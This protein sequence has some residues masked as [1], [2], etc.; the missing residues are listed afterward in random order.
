MQTYI[1][2][3]APK[4]FEHDVLLLS[5]E[6]TFQGFPGHL[7]K[8]LEDQG[9]STMLVK[10]QRE[11]EREAIEYSRII[12]IILSDSYATCSSRLDTLAEIQNDFATGR[13]IFPIFHYVDPSVVRKRSGSYKI[14]LDSKKEYVEPDKLKNWNDALA[15]LAD[16]L[17][18][19]LERVEY[20]YQCIPKI[21]RE[22][23]KQVPCSV[24]LHRRVHEVN[25]LL[26]SGSDDGVQTVGIW[27]EPGIGKTMIARGV[28]N[29]NVGNGFDFCCFL[30]K[31]GEY[32][33]S[34][35]LEDLIRMLVS[36]IGDNDNN[37]KF[38][39]DA[40]VMS[41][42]DQK[43]KQ[44]KVFLVLE[45]ICDQQQL[46]V[47][48]ELTNQF[49][50]NSKVIATA[51]KDC[52][53]QHHEIKTYEVERFNKEEALELLSLKS[54]KCNKL[55]PKYMPILEEAETHASG[56]PLILEVIGSYLCGKSPE[57]CKSVLDQYGK[58]QNG[59]KQMIVQISFDSLEKD[60]KRIV[61]CPNEQKK[62]YSELCNDYS[63]KDINRL[64][65]ISLIKFNKDGMM[66]IHDFTKNV[67]RLDCFK[68]RQLQLF[69]GNVEDYGKLEIQPTSSDGSRIYD[70]MKWECR[71]PYFQDHL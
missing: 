62:T 47:I 67:L 9:L 50:S 43:L 66:T 20:E 22:I 41:K 58:I 53:L 39:N 11:L 36:K 29:S 33:S 48:V 25:A 56:V 57:Q 51:E 24:G 5:D 49:G 38:E 7:L 59:K 14:A 4:P 46:Q 12:I 37:Y 61:S 71:L 69:K 54:S 52:F 42:F 21:I 18:W 17:G 23:S 63:E 30:D 40:E 15:G 31:M 65:D 3:R 32:L 16:R 35:G 13:L 44:N 70:P 2:L 27:G 8:S 1:R 6:D 55:I 60:Q 10:D 19:H 28:Y 68:Q 45:D 64:L 26:Y 34:H